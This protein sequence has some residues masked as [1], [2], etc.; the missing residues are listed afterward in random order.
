MFWSQL[1]FLLLY[2]FFYHTTL[3]FSRFC[4]FGKNYWYGFCVMVYVHYY[5]YLQI[6]FSDYMVDVTFVESIVHKGL[7]CDRETTTL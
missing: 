4:E 2:F 6:E 7:S 5:Q 3:A 1:L